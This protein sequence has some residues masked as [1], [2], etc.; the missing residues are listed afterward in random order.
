MKEKYYGVTQGSRRRL[1]RGR[2]I[3]FLQVSLRRVG[4]KVAIDGIYGPQTHAACQSKQGKKI[5]AYCYP[6]LFTRCLYFIADIEGYGFTQLSEDNLDG[7]T[8]GL[9]GFT[10][11]SES[12]LSVLRETLKIDNAILDYVFGSVYKHV[13]NMMYPERPVSAL[14]YYRAELTPYLREKILVGLRELGIFTSCKQAQ[15]KVAKKEYWDPAL[16]FLQDV[17]PDNFTE[18]QLCAVFNIYVN[19]GGISH[20][21]KLPLKKAMKLNSVKLSDEIMRCVSDGTSNFKQKPQAKRMK[22]IFKG[23]GEINKSFY[24]LS[25]WGIMD[26]TYIKRKA[27][28]DP[29]TI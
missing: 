21:L 9:I 3:E 25:D 1:V 2:H 22:A 10:L 13:F 8:W 16:K 20:E 15:I 14:E 7:I 17:A 11:R 27:L 26:M 19:F 23:H 5:V 12:L 18:Q 24:D 6:G 4:L 28:Q 29:I